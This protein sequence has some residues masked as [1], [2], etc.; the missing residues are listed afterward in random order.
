MKSKYLIL[1]RCAITSIC[2]CLCT[3]VFAESGVSSTPG[4][5]IVNNYGKPV[6]VHVDL[7]EKTYDCINNTYLNH[8]TLKIVTD[9]HVIMTKNKENKWE[10]PK[11]EL[12]FVPGEN[13]TLISTYYSVKILG[14]IRLGEEATTLLSSDI[15]VNRIDNDLGT[16][17]KPFGLEY[18]DSAGDDPVTHFI[19]SDSDKLLKLEAKQGAFTK[20]TITIPAPKPSAEPSKAAVHPL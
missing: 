7:R 1:T 5:T 4:I 10:I 11:H 2:L 9:Y 3:S 14:N 13:S 6:S 18:T 16:A 19:T 15:Y 8:K 12:S 20:M 17:M